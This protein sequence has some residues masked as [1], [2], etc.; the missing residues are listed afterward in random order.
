M[1]TH[2]A[3]CEEAVPPHGARLVNRIAT[4]PQRDALWERARAL[5]HFR[6][7]PHHLSDLEMLAI[8]AAEG[9]TSSCSWAA[10]S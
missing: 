8:G 4:G 3:P 7:S 10:S 6:L 1:L 9:G 5:P 2:F